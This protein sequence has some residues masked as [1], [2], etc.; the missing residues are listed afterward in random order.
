[1][2][3][4][5]DPGPFQVFASFVINQGRISIGSPSAPYSGKVVFNITDEADEWLIP[6]DPVDPTKNASSPHSFGRR[7]SSRSA[8]LTLNLKA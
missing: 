2:G 7:G 8:L 6:R 4:V 1:L 3:R 5:V